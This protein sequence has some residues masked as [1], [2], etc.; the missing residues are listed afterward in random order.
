MKTVLHALNSIE[1]NVIKGLLLSEGISCEI[2]GE[3][4]QGAMGELPASGFIRI[5]VEDNDFANASTII[6]NWRE[7]K[8]TA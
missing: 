8:F 6:E 2:F 5:V 3:Y 1:A 4:L 7:A